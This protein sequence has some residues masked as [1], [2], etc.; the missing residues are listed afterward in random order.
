DMQAEL[1][2][3]NLALYAKEKSAWDG[4]GLL[5]VVIAKHT[6]QSSAKSIDEPLVPLYPS[7]R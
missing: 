3:L 6:K 1:A 5:Q 4:A 7:Q 2:K